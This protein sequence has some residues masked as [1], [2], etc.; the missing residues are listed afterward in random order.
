MC[1]KTVVAAEKTSQTDNGF[2]ETNQPVP[3]SGELKPVR[4]F[5]GTAFYFHLII[6]DTA[7]SVKVFL[8]YLLF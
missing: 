7:F 4:A 1:L 8:M 2:Q 3:P 5:A 6:F